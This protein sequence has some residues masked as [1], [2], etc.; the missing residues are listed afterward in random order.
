MTQW[1]L[2]RYETLRMLGRGG[3]GTTWLCR[4]EAT[5]DQVAVKL[6]R[7]TTAPLL[8]SVRREAE[9]LRGTRHPNLGRLLR[10]SRDRHTAIVVTQYIDGAP[11]DRVSCGESVLVDGL[12]GLAALHARGLRHGDVKAENVLVDRN[13]RGIVIDLGACAPFGSVGEAISGTLDHAAPEVRSGGIADAR[14]DLYSFGVM[15]SRLPAFAQRWRS[16]WT[17]LTAADPAARPSTAASVIAAIAPDASVVVPEPVPVGWVG[18]SEVMVAVDRL[19][20]SLRDATRTARALAIVGPAGS[21]RTRALAEI[22]WRI[23]DSVDVLEAS[24]GA[25]SYP[26][27]AAVARRADLPP[28][29][30]VADIAE[31][32]ER[33][34]D[35]TARMI[36]VDGVGDDP[37]RR[38]HIEALVRAVGD[39]G[40]LAVIV[41]DSAPV[42][43]AARVD[44]A[45]LDTAKVHDWLGDYVPEGDVPAL[46]ACAQ[47]RPA[48]IVRLAEDLHNGRVTASELPS[49]AAICDGDPLRAQQWRA[50]E[51]RL[52][53]L[54][55]QLAVAGRDADVLG[56]SRDDL[57]ALAAAGWVDAATDRV[58]ADD[59][60]AVL[61]AA[62]SLQRTQWYRIVAARL[63][64]HPERVLDAARLWALAGDGHQVAAIL[65]VAG[66]ADPPKVR[67]AL[68]LLASHAVSDRDDAMVLAD[69]AL[70]VALPK[71]A[72]Q[73]AAR[74]RR[75]GALRADVL[76][77]AGAADADLGATARAES[78]L[79]T[80]L[81][82]GCRRP[83]AAAAALVTAL[84]KR[85]AFVEALAVVDAH[86]QPGPGADR[87]AL[88][89]VDA[90]AQAAPTADPLALAELAVSA[91][92]AAG[93]AGEM[94][95]AH[96]ELVSVDAWVAAAPA[97][98]P[99]QR[100]ELRAVLARALVELRS[101]RA[102]AAADRYSDALVIAR[103]IGDDARALSTAINLGVASHQQ[104]G[105]GAALSAYSLGVRLAA[106][107]AQPAPH[108]RT[109]FNLG[110]L[111]AD[112]AQPELAR[113][114]LREAA[115]RARTF[116][117]TGVEGAAALSLAGL[118]LADRNLVEAEPLL[119]R[120]AEVLSTT[121][122]SREMAEM[123][124]ARASAG[125]LVGD[126]AVV[127]RELAT[128]YVQAR[129]ASASDVLARVHLARA[130]AELA[131][132]RTERALAELDL[133][134]PLAETVGQRLL[135]AEVA[136]AHADALSLLG[137]AEAARSARARATEIVE[138]VAL[139]LPPH[140]RS[141][142]R[143]SRIPRETAGA[144][145]RVAHGE[146]RQLLAIYRRLAS[147]DS[148]D[149][150]L[151]ATLDAAIDLAGAERGFLLIVIDEA[152]STS[153]FDVPVA[154][155][156]DREQIGRSHLKFSRTIA[157]DVVKRG[158]AVV[159]TDAG[160]D[161]RFRSHRSVHAMRLKSVL[162]VPI[163][164]SSGVVGAIY[165]DH[166]FKA[167]GFDTHCLELVTACADQ[168]ALALGRARLAEQLSARTRELE[169]ERAQVAALV[170]EQRAQ[171]ADLS[172]ALDDAR[173]RAPVSSWPGIVGNS[174]AL[175]EALSVIDRAAGADVTVLIRGESGTGKE[176]AARAL[177]QRSA[178]RD[179]SFVA[180]N[181]GALPE[182][183]LE[184]ELFGYERGAFTGADRART[185]LLAAAS[186]GTIFLDEI[187]E[188]PL[189][190][191]VKLLRVLQEREVRPLGAPNGIA[192]DVRVVAATHRDLAA[193]VQTG[194]FREDL[195]Y[196]LAVV[197]VVMPALRDRIEDIPNLAL[198][199]LQ[200]VAT[201]LQ[202]PL[203][204]LDPGALRALVR[205]AWPGNVR[206]LRNVLTK[207]MVLCERGV[208][209]VN[210]LGLVETAPTRRRRRHGEQPSSADLESA[211]QTTGSRSA[212]AAKLGVSRA[213]FYRWLSRR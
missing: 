127:E 111:Y 85:G 8:E 110:V 62:D 211:V 168:A 158:E 109:L 54:V 79:K 122:A 57:A 153:R 77:I 136:A 83:L 147:A 65:R 209:T 13:G 189:A 35:G 104:G 76:A 175:V 11:I 7:A 195:Y 102:R 98:G 87:L 48:A 206:E 180:I 177:H 112:I 34:A 183:L 114:A 156:L 42:A 138:R 187:G 80:A 176:L 30:G 10:V 17:Q 203:P 61:A 99:R 116:H 46:T 43:A 63:A 19:A 205:H 139:S 192:I 208:I 29:R 60:H 68:M 55:G 126:H 133:A 1:I 199:V 4:D 9:A 58:V 181:C 185:G 18:R 103:T 145:S 120:A 200:Q 144:E 151:R 81:S 72:T 3:A 179:G 150:V 152:N 201:E 135:V 182:P 157:Q 188:M 27:F 113:Q 172:A 74:A 148:S 178:R 130:K 6:L 92:M 132:G 101:G 140:L 134:A 174:P 169:A 191:Q 14:S 197:E 39:R 124:L 164:G 64:S 45:P 93:S 207:A 94:D 194:R 36:L 50:L 25:V 31:M 160:E 128:S 212:A 47:G 121:G 166:R 44:L 149:E 41:A 88:P 26:A 91:A 21:G 86:M 163:V 12:R 198:A 40:S 59:A 38:M 129:A 108:C 170:A 20:A 22:S 154:R 37:A 119:A 210:D 141:R 186:G 155:N 82:G 165:L 106:A 16:L 75:L 159:T 196:R 5:G 202:R 78:R 193:D 23:A 105:L 161:P 123:A 84:N 15:M 167:G 100:L 213:T 66:H 171:L 143:E 95:R 89:V 131:A 71:L 97:G 70:T 90:H 67:A 107:L 53:D 125:G 118:A 162:C 69:H 115:E 28:P 173:A 2:D 49:V 146:L 52:C 142:L 24:P 204:S 51:P 96:S 33:L 32:V 73:L 56:L 117:V 184:A 190:M 137:A